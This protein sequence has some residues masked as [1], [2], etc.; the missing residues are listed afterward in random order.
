MRN[1]PLPNSPLVSGGKKAKVSDFPLTRGI[2]G[3]F[4]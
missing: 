2:K 1:K 3:V 4:F